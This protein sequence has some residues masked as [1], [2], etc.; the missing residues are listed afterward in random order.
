VLDDLVEPHDARVDRRREVDD[1][2]AERGELRG[3][4]RLD[5]A[6]KALDLDLQP[7]L[8]VFK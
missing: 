7:P 6:R 8:L 5:E 1:R 4:R 3:R 2:A